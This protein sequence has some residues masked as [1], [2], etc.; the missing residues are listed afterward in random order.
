MQGELPANFKQ[1]KTI[2]DDLN[3]TWEEMF[4]FK[5]HSVE[6]QELVIEVWDEDNAVTGDELLGTCQVCHVVLSQIDE[7]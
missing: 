3:P 7:R 1:T 2:D 6:I 5:V 4:Q